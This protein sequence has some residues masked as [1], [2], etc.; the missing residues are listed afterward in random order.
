MLFFTATIDKIGINPFV[1]LP[2]KVLQHIMDA[3]KK[4]KGPVPVQLSIAG[5]AFTQTLVKYAG[6]W[7][8]YLNTPMRKTAGK[9]VGDK[10][11]I[12]IAFDESKR[13]TDM[14]P[15]LLK[16]L[17]RDAHAF[18]VFR[19]LPPSRQKEIMRYIGQLKSAAAVAANVQRAVDFLN[20]KQRFIG[21]DGP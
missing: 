3:A 21:R 12:G 19:S 4:Q 8:L 1:S 13:E 14:P 10:I 5:A 9:D 6:Q 2:D 17:E 20:G 16:A 18:A 15:E 7:R 11:R